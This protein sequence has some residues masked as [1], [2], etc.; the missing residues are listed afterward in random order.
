MPSRV[1]TNY[2][3]YF[4]TKKS[5]QFEKLSI[6]PKQLG[7]FSDFACH[8]WGRYWAFWGNFPS[9]LY[10]KKWPAGMC[11]FSFQKSSAVL[12]SV[13]QNGNAVDTSKQSGDDVPVI[14]GSL[15][16]SLFGVVAIVMVTFLCRR[17]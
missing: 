2:L 7:N 1:D 10:V 12:S 6:G 15:F 4:K 9:S 16:G 5:L 13:I 17:K 11:Y 8:Y 3:E 14:V